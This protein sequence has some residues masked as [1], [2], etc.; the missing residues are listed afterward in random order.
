[1]VVYKVMTRATTLLSIGLI[2]S[3][4]FTMESTRAADDSFHPPDTLVLKNGRTVQGLILKN[5]ADL[6]LLQEEFKEVSYPKSEIVRILDRAD[7]DSVYTGVLRKGELPAWRSIANDLRTIDTIKSLVEIPATVID[8]GEFR[9]VPYKSFRVN[10][11]VELNVYGDPE[12]PAGIEIGVFGNRSSREELRRTIR[13]YLAGFLTTRDEISK[14]YAIDLN[15]GE[16][17]S[18]DMTLEITPKSAPDAYGAWWISLY[19]PKTL[20][21]VRLSDKDYARLTRPMDE[22]VDRKGRVINNGW[23]EESMKMTGRKVPGPNSQ[24]LLR[25]FYRDADGVFRLIT[26]PVPKSDSNRE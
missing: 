3:G 4:L 9:N 22:V 11:D 7:D 18:G 14:L 25:G 16:A 26:E 2:L 5:T 20:D 23:S 17:T 24:V 10:N 1:M 21:R 6:I 8:K 12:S 15:G 13:A 19:K